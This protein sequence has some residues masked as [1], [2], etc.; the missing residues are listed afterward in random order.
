[1]LSIKYIAYACY[2]PRS[3][4]SHNGGLVGLKSL[5]QSYMISYLLHRWIVTTLRLHI[6]KVILLLFSA[7]YLFMQTEDPKCEVHA[8][9]SLR[10]GVCR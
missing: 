10:F 5:S 9:Y 2:P 6:H 7:V 1:M 8:L 3:D 4:T